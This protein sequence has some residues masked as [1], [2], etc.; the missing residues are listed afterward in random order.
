MQ[1]SSNFYYPTES[2]PLGS[3]E[4]IYSLRANMDELLA[5]LIFPHDEN[6]LSRVLWS[7]P[8]YNFIRRIEMLAET[9]NSITIDNLQLPYVSY[10]RDD[11]WEYDDRP[12]GRQISSQVNK[13]RWGQ[14]NTGVEGQAIH[15]QRS[16]QGMILFATE[17]DAQIALDNLFW[18]SNRPVWGEYYI[19]AA[20]T[21]VHIPATYFLESASLAPEQNMSEWMQ[22]QKM[23][24]VTFSFKV[25][26]SLLRLPPA[27]TPVYMTE[28]VIHYF[29]NRHFDVPEEALPTTMEGWQEIADEVFELEMEAGGEV[30]GLSTAGLANITLSVDGTEAT[31]SWEYIGDTL[32]YFIEFYIHRG[33]EIQKDPVYVDLENPVT[34]NTIYGL[35][36]Q[37]LYDVVMKVSYPGSRVL[38]YHYQIQTDVFPEQRKGLHGLK[39]MTL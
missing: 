7:H 18:W 35:S 21:R 5:K 26:T 4:Q 16:F 3:V 31:F 34:S 17:R 33:T 32:P 39:G 20:D 9:G 14:D 12:A 36:G 27:S 25:Y 15:A 19:Y 22:Q 30:N 37:S 24:V 6:K 38:K 8:N 13:V 2:L 10:Y 28:S 29:H 11:A 1:L 23:S